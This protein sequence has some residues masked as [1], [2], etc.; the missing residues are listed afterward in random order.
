MDFREEYDRLLNIVNASLEVCIEEKDTPEGS[1]Y[2]AMRY[3]L[4]AGGKRL[5]PVLSLAVCKLLG[6][7]IEMVLPFACALE[8]I[9]SY[10]LIHDDLPSM[11]NDNYRRGRLTNHKVFGEAQAILAGDALLNFAFEHM[12]AYTLRNPRGLL[13]KIEAMNI[14]ARASGASGMIGGQVVDLQ[15]EGIQISGEQLKYMHSCKTGALIKAAILSAAALC[16]A[17]P[18]ERSALE[19]Y[20]D[21]IG[22]AFQI[23]DDIL[24][25]EGTLEDLGK[26]TG[27]DKANMKSTFVTIYGL[28]E[29]KN[30]LKDIC[31][32]AE[33]ALAPFGDRGEFL[34]ELAEYIIFRKT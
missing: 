13:E 9:H 8:M 19:E 30:M 7:E 33:S 29:S 4:L 16:G 3:S 24:D 10:S 22:L 15:S 11:D 14:I 23:T 27:K 18:N 26:S 5:R 20:G 25:V 31:S 28:E 2:K 12:L 34:R 17:T 1:I 21:G 6:G 32:K